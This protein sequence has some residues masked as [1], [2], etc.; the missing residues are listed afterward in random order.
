M[1]LD[2]VSLLRDAIAISSISG[3]EAPLVAFLVSRLR[4]FGFRARRDGAGNLVAEIGEGPTVHVL[5]GH[6]DTVAG[7][8][9]VRLEDGWLWGR[10]AV[11]A[12]GPLC[13][14]LSAC[15][16]VGAVP[17]HRFVVIGA[18]EEEAPSS[19]GAWA[20]RGEYRPANTII[21]EPSGA[22]ALTLGYK[23]RLLARLEVA[24]RRAHSSIPEPTPA[25]LLVGMWV[26]A[27]A[28]AG[29]T[30]RGSGVF[31]DLQVSLD[32]F[33][34]DLR[35][36]EV[37]ARATLGFRLPPDFDI[38]ALKQRLLDVRP[39][40]VEVEFEGEVPAF[41]AAKSTPVVR[42]FLA[43]M[44]ALG[45]EPGFKVKTGTSDMNVVGPAWGPSI[46]AYGPGESKLDHTPEE[47][48]AVEEYLLGIRVLEGALRRLAGVVP[49]SSGPT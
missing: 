28:H 11:D 43:S 37:E 35:P 2:P 1:T 21:G 5:L 49:R 48:I 8:I 4:E 31:S 40:G 42:A 9:P 10:G 22:S 19:K 26:A 34:T 3:R 46:V 12:K 25:E 32:E 7:E 29:A 27:R 16:R 47:R 33:A 6:L 15:H 38:D 17:G 41:R 45:L 14:F 36:F 23:G 39:E 18:V 13:A 30:A 24:R 20:V 44:R